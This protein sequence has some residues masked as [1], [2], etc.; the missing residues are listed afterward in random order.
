MGGG[1]DA[2]VFYCHRVLGMPVATV[3]FHV[4]TVDNLK[5]FGSY[6]TC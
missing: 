1:G 2:D 6:K 3:G 5:V 4:R